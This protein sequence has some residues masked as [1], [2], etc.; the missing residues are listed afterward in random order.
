MTGGVKLS[1][2]VSCSGGSDVG[3]LENLVLDLF[4]LSQLQ[5]WSSFGK[6]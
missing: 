3:A 4:S 2:T 1:D 5:D 6:K